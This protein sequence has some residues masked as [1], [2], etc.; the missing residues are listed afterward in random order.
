MLKAEAETQIVAEW[1]R[2]IAENPIPRPTTMNAHSF[3]WTHLD[4][5]C[6]H[7]PYSSPHFTIK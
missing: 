6:P 3:Y 2:Y 7:L 1:S 5:K 4:K